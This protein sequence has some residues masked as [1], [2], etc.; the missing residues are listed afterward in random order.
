VIGQVLAGGDALVLMPTGGGKSLCYQLPSLLLPGL[1]VVMSPLIALM[2]DQVRAADQLGIK[3]DFLNSTQSRDEREQVMGACRS[4]ELKLLYLAP[5]RLQTPEIVALFDSVEIS[6][7]AVDEAHCVSQWGHN[8]RPDYLQLSFFKER[9]PNTPLLA[10]TATANDMTRT[11]IIERL[12]I[13][14]ARV[15]IQGFDRPNIYY[16]IQQKKDP[17]RQLAGFLK[18]R[19]GQS[20]IVYCLSRKST[21]QTATWLQGQGYDALPYHAGMD[22]GD[23]QAN[24]QR[25]LEQDG[26]IMVATIAFGMGIDKPDVRF[27]AHLD[28]PKSI[29]GY[30][31]ETGRAGRD[32]E[33]ADAWMIYG[34]ADVTKLQQMVGGNASEQQ[35][36]IEQQ[37]LNS[38]LAFCEVTDC[39]RR[40]LLKYFGEDYDKGHDKGCRHC[41]NCVTP[42]PTFD[43]TLVVQ[44]VL[45]AIYR[46]DQRFGANY[47]IDVL[48][49]NEDERIS[50]FGH[51]RLGVYGL[52]RELSANEWRSVIRQLVVKGF[53]EVD[54]GGYGG[55]R[56]LPAC[57]GVL[58]GDETILLHK[59]MTQGAASTPVKRA[60]PLQD[61][62]YDESLYES[63]R[64]LRGM[65]ASENNLAPF[66]VFHDRTLKELATYMPKN[67]SELLTINGIGEAKAD[68]FGSRFLEV[69]HPNGELQAGG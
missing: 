48:L 36:R 52:G 42:R 43:A 57:R 24:Q 40:V 4:G 35:N 55:L 39:R 58:R 53:V 59:D 10:L 63:L 22:A 67:R 16:Q 1:T 37:K 2:Q 56:L 64:A 21:E 60:A 13:D 44:K 50:R 8:F 30:Y 27:V 47:V 66:M 3:A 61:L 51:D 46:T 32:G 19:T 54:V 69:L 68:R 20:G 65:I 26:V 62:D 7:V 11:E 5:E 28:L 23:R 33:P 14:G 15:F 9:Y 17:R 6:L 25:F 49:G 34:L 12:K 38:M 29:E 31:Q 41:D 45:S 18:G